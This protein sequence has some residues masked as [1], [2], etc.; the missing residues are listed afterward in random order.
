M[1]AAE[2][3]ETVVAHAKP[4]YG[5]LPLNPPAPEEA[6]QA[7]EKDLGL[8]L[9][10]SYK[11]VLRL[12]NGEYLPNNDTP[13]HLFCG[14]T[15]LSIKQVREQYASWQQTLAFWANH[16]DST[17]FTS[18][19]ENAVQP[20]L[21]SASWLPFAGMYS[22]NHLAIDFAP[23][24]RGSVGQV[25]TF[26]SDEDIHYQ[27]APNFEAFLAFILAIYKQGKY[28]PKTSDDFGT[29]IFVTELAKHGA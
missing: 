18:L 16:E 28:Q 9:P 22:G 14:F 1:S 6:I 15:F 27:I 4:Y 26:G 13:L 21:A 19:P 17:I 7:L 23:G 29:D 10:N 20:V 2:L 25:I 12:H 24:P 8:V 11:E 3:F 5:T